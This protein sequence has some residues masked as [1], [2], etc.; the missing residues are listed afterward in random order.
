M[1]WY[2]MLLVT[3]VRQGE[4]VRKFFLHAFHSFEYR[5]L[6]PGT[7]EEG[8][9]LTVNDSERTEEIFSCCEKMKAF[10]KN[11]L[12]ETPQILCSRAYQQGDDSSLLYE[13]TK[14]YAK[15]R[16]AEQILIVPQNAEEGDGTDTLLKR[17]QTYI[18]NHYT[19]RLTLADIAEAVHVSSSYLSR[20]YN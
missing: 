15:G 12:G 1:T 4:K 18:R 3:P 14:A 20:F 9:V 7:E 19:E 8:L 17:V 13:Q 10:C 11:F 2:R 16:S 5:A 6:S